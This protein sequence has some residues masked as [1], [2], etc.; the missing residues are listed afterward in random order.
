MKNILK[1]MIQKQRLNTDINYKNNYKY[2]ELNIIFNLINVWKRINKRRKSQI[3]ILFIL[4]VL[5]GFS[6]FL[7]FSSVIPFLTAITDSKRL[8]NY[9]FISFFYDLFNFTDDKQLIYF[10]TFLF[11][12]MVYFSAIMRVINISINYKL[13]AAIGSDLS[14][15]AYKKTL[16]QPYKKHLGWNS[17]VLVNIIC[18]DINTTVQ[19]LSHSLTILNS[20]IITS[21]IL[22]GLLIVNFKIAIALL[23]I[24]AFSYFLIGYKNRVLIEKNG[25]LITKKSQ[26]RIK[27]L[28]EGLG[29]IKE[30][31][32]GNNQEYYSEIFKNT[33]IP[34]R[35]LTAKNSFL[36]SFPK[37]LL[38][39]IGIT[40]IAITGAIISK[41]GL[42]SEAIALIGFIALGSQRLLPGL[43]NIY[44]SWIALKGSNAAIVN[45]LKLLNQE[46]PIVP[47]EN[48][49]KTFKKNIEF[50]DV[51]FRYETSNK[52]VLNKLNF[53]INFGEKIGII[54]K[55]G[56]GKSTTIDLLMTLI[57]PSKGQILID[58]KDVFNDDARNLKYNWRSQITHVPQLIYLSDNSFYENIAFGEKPNKIDILKVQKAAYE[59]QIADFIESCPNG[60]NTVIGE[61]GIRLSG[62]QRQRIALARAFYNN[63]KFFILDEATSA[64]D[65]NTE[66]SIIESIY[67]LG[68][69][70]TV[71]MIAHRLSTLRKCSK[72]LKFESGSII[73]YG[74]PEIILK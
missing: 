25:Y 72:I 54:G 61:R 50:K 74:D 16:Y 51:S 6:E 27:S 65:S 66:N 60:Y 33:D 64:L 22:T 12:L 71:I 32:L 43:Q 55:T 67:K 57:E 44:S 47:K 41:S 69:E 8:L 20:L 52:L 63:K 1:K 46:V 18:K 70:T 4:M 40:F 34:I 10:T 30:I 28:Q 11:L 62:G 23:S 48:K 36:G 59:A 3:L 15:D 19:G 37:Y 49:L 56:S 13:T 35:M 17:S 24:V 73:E 68:P 58:G 31:L 45:V 21:S 38:E 29:A 2:N 7:T 14:C 53:Q 9:Q 26:L 42:S 5:S 39:T